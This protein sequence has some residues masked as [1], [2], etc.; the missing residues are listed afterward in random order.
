MCSEWIYSL[1]QGIDNEPVRIRQL[2]KSVGC[3][4]NF[5]G[6]SKLDNISKVSGKSE[7]HTFVLIPYIVA[8]E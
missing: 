6:P 1:G 2:P 5:R 3:C 8:R 7:F 4:K